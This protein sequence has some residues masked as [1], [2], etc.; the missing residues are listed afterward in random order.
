MRNTT[1]SSGG[2]RHQD[3]ASQESPGVAAPQPAPAKQAAGHPVETAQGGLAQLDQA[4]DAAA[5][6]SPLAEH[7]AKRHSKKPRL[8]RDSFKFPPDEYSVFDELKLRCLAAGREVKKSELVRAG[9]QTLKSLSDAKL[10]EVLGKLR[11]LKTGRPP[12]T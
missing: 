4:L 1:K 8:L 10:L 7:A 2:R 6:S 9:L 5:G 11:K 12:K 3:R